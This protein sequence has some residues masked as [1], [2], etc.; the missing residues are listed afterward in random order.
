MSN[1]IEHAQPL[2][3]TATEYTATECTHPL[4]IDTFDGIFRLQ[5]RR[6]SCLVCRSGWWDSNGAVIRSTDAVGLLSA[7][8]AG[9]RPTG[10][11]AAEREWRRLAD[12]GLAPVDL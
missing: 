5:L 9:P 8:T 10:W 6:L 12:E 7:L 2:G 1:V 3:G 4:A 11:A